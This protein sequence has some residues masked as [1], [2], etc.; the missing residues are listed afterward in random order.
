MQE[1]RQH[2]LEIL[3]ESGQA[4]VD[5]IVRQ[6]RQ[7]RGAITAVTVRH[8]LTRLQEDN[9]IS[10]PQLRH[11][12]TPGRPQHVYTLTEKAQEY[13]PD[14]YQYLAEGLLR[15]IKDRLP[16][17]GV[18]VIIEG[19]ADNMAADACIEEAP[20]EKRLDHV[21]NYLNQHGYNAAWE[22]TEE[23]FLLHTHNCP[24]HD[25]AQTTDLLCNMDMRLVS[26]LLGVVP[27]MVSRVS[28]GD[29][30]CAYLIPHQ[31]D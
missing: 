22:E 29:A 18:N 2:I 10:T 4:T 14:N 26:S 20:I 31:R 24:Y 19:L 3:K 6:L 25:L 11:R 27:R 17:E 7:R 28:E 9:L 23:G 15:Q 12:S 1:T 30:S 5:D 21:V 13:F 8:H 16:A